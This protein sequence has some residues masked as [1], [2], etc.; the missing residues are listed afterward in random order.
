VNTEVEEQI[1]TGLQGNEEKQLEAV[2][3]AYERYAAPL[4][5]YILE[6]VVPTL[7]SHELTT[8]VNDV[9]I[10]LAKKAK[11]GNFKPDGSL[12]SL[13]F[14]MAR[15]NA[16]DQLREKVRYQYRNE[17]TDFSGSENGVQKSE[18]L[19]DDEIASRVAQK[20]ADAPEIGSAWKAATNKRTPANESAAAEIVRLFRI[21]I[22][23]LPSFQRKV[24]RLMAVYFGDITEEQICDELGKLGKRPPLGS[25]KSARREIREKFVSLINQI[26]RTEK[27]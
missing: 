23:G 8:A 3:K 4:A 10:E 1:K 13:L 18:W 17:L 20:L 16:I 22:A 15:C 24:A 5:A 11:N 14:Q 6:R 9:F 2:C 19:N 25:V 7:D 27:P 12:A 21:H 26:E